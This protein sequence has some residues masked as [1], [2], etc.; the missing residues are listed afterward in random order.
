MTGLFGRRF[1]EWHGLAEVSLKMAGVR[2]EM[3]K[4]EKIDE[5]YCARRQ[6]AL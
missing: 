3:G 2:A 6:A 5:I 1:G 4:K